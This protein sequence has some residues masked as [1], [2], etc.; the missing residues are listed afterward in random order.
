MLPLVIWAPLESYPITV[1]YTCPKCNGHGGTTL[2]GIDWCD[3]HSVHRKPRLI[4]DVNSC[5]LL[6]SRVSY[7]CQNGHEILGHHPDILSRFNAAG[8]RSVIPFRLYHQT[9]FAKDLISYVATL[10]KSG[11]SLQQV[12]KILEEN[13]VHSFYERK[14]RFIALNQGNAVT[15]TF[16]DIDD[17]SVRFWKASP[18][19]HS[20]AACFL[21]QFWE[22]E[23]AYR[24]CMQSLS[25]PVRDMWL[26]CDHTFRS[27]AN[28][29][30]VRNADS[31]WVKQY[32]GLF[33]VLNSLGQVVTWK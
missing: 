17:E 10:I 26:S 18:T 25:V 3:G 9:G 30:M 14:A 22:K 19:R 20:I 8:C 29:G 5:C 32:K 2:K 16:P 28:V 33:C 23:E 7:K 11:I 12:E 27:V 1:S 15:A 13:R 4:H 31:H 6:I 21:L 24:Q